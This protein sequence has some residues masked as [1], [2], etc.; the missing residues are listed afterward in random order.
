MDESGKLSILIDG[1]ASGLNA[2]IAES[3]R[4]LDNIGKQAS[5]LGESIDDVSGKARSLASSL[6]AIGGISLGVAGV[7]QFVSKVYEVRSYFQD[8][9]SSM[10][11]FLGDSQKAADFT[12]KLKDYAWYNMFEFSDLAQASQQ[13]IA[14][15]NDTEKVIPIIHKL[16]EVAVATKQPLMDLVSLYNK[17][18]NQGIVGSESLQSWAA[19]GLVVRDVLKEM[20]DEVKNTSVSFEQLDKVLDYVTSEGQM[21]GGIQAE[22]MDNLS[23]EWGQL[24]DNIDSM[25]NEIGEKMQGTMSQGIKAVAWLVDNYKELGQTLMQLVTIYGAYR[26]VLAIV[27][28]TSKGYTVAQLAQYSALLLVEKAQKLLNATMLKNPYVLAAVAVTA[29]V[30]T[31]VRLNRV[32]D[33]S[34]VA[35][36]KLNTAISELNDTRQKNVSTANGLI[37]TVNDETKSRAEQ[38]AALHELKAK[39]PEI[40]AKYIDENGQLRDKLALLKEI[41]KYETKKTQLSKREQLENAK[42]ALRLATSW[43]TVFSSNN[44]TTSDWSYS[45]KLTQPLFE[46]GGYNGRAWGSHKRYYEEAESYFQTYIQELQKEV[47]NDN[48]YNFIASI[49]RLSDAELNAIKKELEDTEKKTD[50]EKRQLEEV[51]G[52]L[53]QRSEL[54]VTHDYDYWEKKK[55]DAQKRLKALSDTEIASQKGATIQA[56]IAEYNRKLA[57]YAT[58][59]KTKASDNSTIDLSKAQRE[60]EKAARDYNNAVTRAEIESLED[61][62]TKTIR[63]IEQNNKERLEAIDDHYNE[64]VV[65]IAKK[66]M[67]AYKKSH[68][69]S[70]AGFVFDASTDKEVAELTK[71]KEQM[72]LTLA[73]ETNAKIVAENKRHYKQLMADRL[74]YLQ[75]YG[76]IEQQKLAIAEEYAEKIAEAENQWQV[77]SLEA[78][79]EKALAEI[80]MKFSRAYAKIF[81]DVA[82]MTTS[83]IR[84]AISLA[85]TEMQRLTESGKDVSA[86]EYK[87]LADQSVKL[88]QELLGAG[89]KGWDT[90]IANVIKKVKNLKF[91]TEEMTLENDRYNA[92]IQ[93][94][95]DKLAELERQRADIEADGNEEEI[96]RFNTEI[97]KLQGKITDSLRAQENANANNAASIQRAR[98]ELAKTLALTGVDVLTKSLSTAA[99]AMR[100]IAEYSGDSSLAD[101]ADMLSSFG[102]NLTA[103][104]EGAANGG[105][106]GAIIGGVSDMAQQTIDAISSAKANEEMFAY[107]HREFI[108]QINL[109]NLSLDSDVYETLFGT[110]EIAKTTDAMSKAQQALAEYNEYVNKL[111]QKGPGYAEGEM[112]D[113]RSWGALIFTG[114]L[115]ATFGAEAGNKETNLYKQRIDAMKRGLTDLQAMSVNITHKSGWAKF[116]GAQDEYKSLIDI[117]PELWGED[118]E[119]NVENAKL[120]LET[121]KQITTEQRSQIQHA[122]DLK[123]AYDDAIDVIK[124]DLSDTF[125]SLADNLSDTIWDAVINGADAWESFNEIGSGVIESLGKKLL[126]SLIQEKYLQKYEDSLINAYGI[127]DPTERTR[128][129][130]RIYGEIQSEYPTILSQGTAIVQDLADL[131]ERLNIDLDAETSATTRGIASASQ[132]TVDELNG[133]FTAIQGHTYEMNENVKAL[134]EQNTVLVSNVGNILAQLMGIHSDTSDMR[135]AQARIE[136]VQADIHGIVSDIGLRCRQGI[137][138]V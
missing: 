81:G 64:Q 25:F 107:Q 111:Y 72:V 102:Q 77:R 9:E 65:E 69:D 133:R 54:N 29:L 68:D 98:A 48:I 122:I 17:N 88:R 11:V 41:E 58:G 124:E 138:I 120:F 44:W 115:S 132:D 67:E 104:G 34:A 92:A 87:A 117:A 66:R 99:D 116:W 10:R 5:Q 126:S 53:K 135:D 21:F 106:I 30:T 26:V 49:E 93:T 12:A 39:Y 24:Q 134:R 60:T 136:S 96:L 51:N 80:D 18:K 36:E 63:T 101:T 61:G 16:S 42:K 89:F 59:K 78:Q 100:R 125:G 73:V 4:G 46:K 75:E 19:K 43:K 6:A 32:Q 57:L 86:D 137:K 56:E 108:R 105:W 1:N 129:L 118:G 123:E 3:G 103:A 27:T 20:G 22:M 131:S 31:L 28:A 112:R 113:V 33:Q 83:Q 91:L 47:E 128:E 109:A 38:L 50:Y 37:E 84:E 52:L 23:S 14:Y 110:D 7:Q 74:A 35:T 8:I 45:L 97:A 79:R 15:G 13:L 82:N 114:G 40:I 70:D 85:E 94:L 119:F 62:H 95:T 2:A 121:N 76:S 90:G 55:N 71:Q 127:E 130:A